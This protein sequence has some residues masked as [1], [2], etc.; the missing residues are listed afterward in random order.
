MAVKVDGLCWRSGEFVC[1]VI[2]LVFSSV[3]RL[4]GGLKGLDMSP[5]VLSP[6]LW[7][8]FRCRLHQGLS[9]K[10]NMETL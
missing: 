4:L 1:S 6:P 8:S 10:A 9:H 5:L 3:S 7:L 2:V